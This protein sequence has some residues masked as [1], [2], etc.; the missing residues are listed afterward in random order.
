MH[1][2]HRLPNSTDMLVVRY[3]QYQWWFDLPSWSEIWEDTMAIPQYI[4][5]NEIFFIY[6]VQVVNLSWGLLVMRHL[7]YQKSSQSCILGRFCQVL[8]H[9]STSAAPSKNA[10]SANIKH[11]RYPGTSSKTSYFW[12][13]HY[14]SKRLFVHMLKMW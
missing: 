12:S 3:M 14:C 10:V 1:T 8:T 5:S 9:M 7:S 4:A 2:Y 6:F 13:I 11:T